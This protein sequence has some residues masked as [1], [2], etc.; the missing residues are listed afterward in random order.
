MNDTPKEA[1]APEDPALEWSLSFARGYFELGMLGRAEAELKKIPAEKQELPDVM[2]LRSHLLV[3][4]GHWRRV[5]KHARRAVVLFPQAPE[6]YIHAATAFDMLGLP[7]EGRRV[8]QSAPDAVRSSGFFHLHVARFEARLGNVAS[9]RDH[10]AHAFTLDPELRFV[11]RRDPSL[12]EIASG[13][14]KN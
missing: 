5:V 8:W 4:R 2:S 7:A 11:A 6:Y 10:L 14:A 9:A 13:L 1:E 3:A 12:A